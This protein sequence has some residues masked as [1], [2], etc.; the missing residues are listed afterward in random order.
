MIRQ[1]LLAVVALFVLGAG[2]NLPAQGLRLG[3]DPD[4]TAY[5]VNTTSAPLSFDGY[6][7]AS[8]T[9]QLDPAGWKSIGDQVS[10]D[11][12]GII[13][14]LGAGALAFGEANPNPGNLA[15][16]NIAGVG[17][18]QAGQKFYL[19]KPFGEGGYYVG[20]YYKAG[21]GPD[22]VPQEPLFIPRIPEPSAFLLAA[23]A[24]LGLLAFRQRLS[25]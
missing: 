10:A 24:G 17:T 1:A 14:K 8:E 7:I 4:L 11:P 5:L 3:F 12:L 9:G 19:G 13:T 15:E 25:Q 18:L 20:F 16:L 21:T 2:S 22:A 23:L 6:Q